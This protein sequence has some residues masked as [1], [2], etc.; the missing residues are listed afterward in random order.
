[1]YKLSSILR[2]LI[3]AV[4]VILTVVYFIAPTLL[5]TRVNNNNAY[6]VIL[7]IIGI[8]M[9]FIYGIGYVPKYKFWRF[10]VNPIMVII[11]I[12]IPLILLHI[13]K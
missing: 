9:G 2:W 6:L 13:I 3:L 5:V 11:V 7:I 1:M 8:C 4:C 12:F 10:F